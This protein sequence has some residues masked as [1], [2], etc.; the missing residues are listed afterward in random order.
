MSVCRFQLSE[1]MARAEI[2]PSQTSC[3]NWY[4]WKCCATN[5]H[6]KMKSCSGWRVTLQLLIVI[7]RVDEIVC[8]QSIGWMIIMT[9]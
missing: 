3:E 8:Q 9:L 6:E 7:C 4:E 5:Y 2:I 1:Y